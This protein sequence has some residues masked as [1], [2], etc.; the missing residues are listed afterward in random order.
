MCPDNNNARAPASVNAG[1]IANS[2]TAACV[3][4]PQIRKE[5]TTNFTRMGWIT[6]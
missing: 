3:H 6:N 4:A 1:W 2:G 5:A